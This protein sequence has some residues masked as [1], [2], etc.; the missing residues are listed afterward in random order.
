MI[1]GGGRFNRM[2][3]TRSDGQTAAVELRYGARMRHHLAALLCMLA[4]PAGAKPPAGTPAAADIP[5]ALEDTRIVVQ[6]EVKPGQR[7]PFVFDSGLSRGHIISTHAA[8]ALGLKGGEKLAL[9][10]ADGE[11]REAANLRL[12]LLRIGE[13]RLRDQPLAILDLP[14]E[15]TARAG[16]VPLAGFVGAPLME[17]AVLCIDYERRVMTRWA[18]E[19]FDADG[20]TTLPMHLRQGLPTIEANI[21]GHRA[22]L[23]VDTGSNVAL[24]VYP[25]FAERAEFARRYPAFAPG[26]AHTGGALFETF[27]G[28]AASVVLAA[29]ARFRGVPMMLAPQGF[30]PAW[31][32]DGMIGYELLSMLHP[33][34][35]RDGGRLLFRRR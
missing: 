17:Q 24:V 4:V 2:G 18:R 22:A 8:A 13:A 19:T 14:P 15:R 11:R 28:E 35:D 34:L 29:N 9:L 30:D 20:H 1:G 27:E 31:G 6:V 25:S 21:D 12:D 26:T 33:C 16:Q 7:L 32:I 10:S 3:R 5:F 23:I